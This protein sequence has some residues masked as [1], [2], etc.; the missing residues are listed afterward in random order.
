MAVQ[1]FVVYQPDSLPEVHPWMALEEE[2]RVDSH[3]SDSPVT[4]ARL[5][6]LP[7]TWDSGLPGQPHVLI[8]QAL[9]ADPDLRRV[10]VLVA[11]L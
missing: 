1:T 2:T 10:S 4:G 7:G 8:T 3:L 6:D 5:M 11:W 9:V